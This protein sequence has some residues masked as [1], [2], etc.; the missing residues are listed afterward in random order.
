M[1][2][3]IEVDLYNQNFPTGR[4]DSL[5][6]RFFRVPVS[7]ASLCSLFNSQC[8]QIFFGTQR[9]FYGTQGLTYRT[10]GLHCWTYFECPASR[11]CLAEQPELSY[12]TLFLA[13]RG[14][15]PRNS[16][17]AAYGFSDFC[18]YGKPGL[19]YGMLCYFY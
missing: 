9:L 3:C 4:K 18:P 12:G 8:Q 5:T 13:S 6:G 7:L 11:N 1:Q 17:G 10:P 16:I 14:P 15:L 2:V 19:Y